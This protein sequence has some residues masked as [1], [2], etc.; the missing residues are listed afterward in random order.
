MIK[1]MKNMKNI[2]AIIL[3][4]VMLVATS[5]NKYL[6]INVDPNNATS[7]SADLILPQALNYTAGLINSFNGYGAQV[8]GYAAN[9]GGYGGFGTS[10]TYNF[11]TAEYAG[12]FSSSFDLLEDYQTIINKTDGNKNYAYHN[13]AARIMKAL[14]YQL[15]VDT[16]NDVPY[17]EALSQG[18]KPTLTP[19]YDAA[20]SVYKACADELDKA[21]ATFNTGAANTDVVPLGTSD[22]MFGGSATKWKQLANTIKLRLLVRGAGKVT[23]TNNTFSSDGFLTT[24]ALINPGY[25]RD[26]GKQN[27]KWNN[28]GWGYTGSPGTKS[29]M[30]STFIMTFYNSVKLYDY[31]RGKATYYLFPAT[32][33]NQLGNESVNVA[34]C[35]DGTFWFPSTSRVGSSAGNTIGVLKGPNAGLPLITA[36]ESYFIQAEAALKGIITSTTDAAAFDNGI[37]ASFK[38]LYTL[39][40]GSISGNPTA[41]AATYLTDNPTSFLVNYGLAT[42]TAQKLEAIL[43]QKWVALNFVN[44]DQSWNDYRRTGYPKLNNAPGATSTETFASKVSE[45]TRPDRLPTRVLYPVAEGSY[46]SANVPKGIS[47]FTS[48]IFWAQ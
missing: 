28:W 43:T 23:F 11:S 6:D 27:P 16:Y 30:P 41:D 38:Y 34:S 40:D 20:A 25:V 29:W 45:S 46:N 32:P 31:G 21:I 4:G 15:L 1:N 8:G 3:S 48:L 35:P 2:T 42:T 18:T 9:A 17:T 14:H 47:P 39:P 37:K 7:A 10:I 13:G 19:K 24:D 36:A 44:S 5:C 33:T 12:L 26:N 22:I